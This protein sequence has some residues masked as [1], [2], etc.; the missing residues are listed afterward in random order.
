MIEKG[1]SFEKHMQLVKLK[2]ENHKMKLDLRKS[3]AEISRL[4][5]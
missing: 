3:T 4:Q 5:T 1:Q 2:Q